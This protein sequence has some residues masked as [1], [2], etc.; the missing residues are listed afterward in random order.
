VG[1]SY[2]PSIS[3]KTPSGTDARRMTAG[4]WLVSGLGVGLEMSSSAGQMEKYSPLFSS[5]HSTHA[6]KLSRGP[7]PGRRA[8]DHSLRFEM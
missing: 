2:K 4:C 6:A 5:T 7:L 8:L 3:T 1:L